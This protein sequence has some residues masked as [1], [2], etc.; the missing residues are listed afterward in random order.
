M[1]IELSASQLETAIAQGFPYEHN[2]GLVK[3]ILEAPSIHIESN[4]VFIDVPFSTK[5]L[6]KKDGVVFTKGKVRYD[7]ETA[8]IYIDESEII[9][10]LVDGKRIDDKKEAD[11]YRKMGNRFVNKMLSETPVYTFEGGIESFTSQFLKDVRSDGDK[12]IIEMG[13]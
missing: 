10:V 3:A 2:E 7:K 11:F 8:S 12:L 6:V 9:S 1:N 4:T 5:G 13:I